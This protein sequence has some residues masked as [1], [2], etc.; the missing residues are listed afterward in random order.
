MAVVSRDVGY[1]RILGL[2]AVKEVTVPQRYC[3]VSPDGFLKRRGKV[4]VR[5]E[6]PTLLSIV[7]HSKVKQ[8]QH[9]YE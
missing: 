2:S 6:F 5:S 9:F 7:G 8:V 4:I 3:T 1:S